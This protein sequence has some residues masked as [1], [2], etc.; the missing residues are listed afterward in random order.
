[1]PLNF[2]LCKCLITGETSVRERGISARLQPQRGE[3]VL[4]FHIDNRDFRR[5]FGAENEPVCDGVF[6]YKNSADDAVLL[7]VELKGSDFS[8][9]VEQVAHVVRLFRRKLSALPIEF[10]AVVVLNAGVPPDFRERQQRFQRENGV[11]LRV[12]KDGDLRKVLKD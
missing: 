4:A 6:F 8:R 5:A 1:M 9:A 3:C 12:S 7:C 11:K 2:L 10:R